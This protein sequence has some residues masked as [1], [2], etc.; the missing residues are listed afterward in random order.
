MLGRCEEQDRAP[1]P[2]G[3]TVWAYNC[4]TEHASRTDVDVPIHILAESSSCR[5]TLTCKPHCSSL[6]EK[7]LI[8]IIQVLEPLLIVHRGTPAKQSMCGWQGQLH[9]VL[10]VRTNYKE[11]S[12]PLE[13][14]HNTRM[15]RPAHTI[16]SVC[17]WAFYLVGRGYIFL[18]GRHCALL[19]FKAWHQVAI[20]WLLNNWRATVT[21]LLHEWSL[22]VHQ[23]GLTAAH[24]Q[25]R[26]LGT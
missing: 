2:I 13:Q 3:L 17:L 18:E 15:K 24:Y 8:R 12:C 23:A 20:H 22:F 19:I 6:A 16:L 4:N 25:P 10:D 14:N 7:K 21:V 9:S 1:T 11:T 5:T 26:Q